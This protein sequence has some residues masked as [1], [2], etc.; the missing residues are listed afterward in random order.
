MN[1]GD[2]RR[3]V[4]LEQLR[5]EDLIHFQCLHCASENRPPGSTIGP[6]QLVKGC[7][8]EGYCWLW[9]YR[10]G[11]VPLD[12]LRAQIEA[13]LALP[14]PERLERLMLLVTSRGMGEA[15]TPARDPDPGLPV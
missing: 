14:D 11:G 7:P 5:P 2:F 6:E 9:P 4:L 3:W 15:I 1:T 10:L 8:D 13:A 12:V